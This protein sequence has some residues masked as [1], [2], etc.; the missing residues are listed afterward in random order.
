MILANFIQNPAIQL[1][2]LLWLVG[3]VLA[4]LTRRPAWAFLLFYVFLFNEAILYPLTGAD[5][6]RP[7]WRTEMYYSGQSLPEL[8]SSETEAIHSNYTEG[9]YRDCHTC[10]SP[11]K[12]ETDRFDHF[13]ELLDLRPG[14]RVLDAGCGMG[15]MV[16]YFRQRGIEAYGITITKTQY[17]LCRERIGDYFYYGDYTHFRHELVARFDSIIIPGSLEHPFGGHPGKASS[18]V[19]KNKK[20]ATLFRMMKKYFRPESTS[21]KILTTVIHMNTSYGS[22][23]Q[24]YVVERAFGGLYPAM[25]GE[26]SVAGAMRKAGYRIRMDRDYSWHY[27][28][29]SECDRTHFGNPFDIGLPLALLGGLVY[30][31][32]W[33]I[34]LYGNHGYWM[35]QWDAQNHYRGRDDLTFEPDPARR[36]VSLLYTVAQL[37]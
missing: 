19:H 18:Y 25:G 23:W 20:M 13:I 1:N 3:I 30:P 29:A 28:R 21:K 9:Y 27:Y 11:Q 22:T 10:T 12:S 35:W 33:Y 37:S 5:I 31:H 15:G 7:A 14:D 6:Y 8:E 17:E 34:Y 2:L 24:S 4:V 26:L 36:P 32:V 16:A